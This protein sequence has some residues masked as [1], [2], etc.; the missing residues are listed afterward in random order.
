MRSAQDLS[1]RSTSVASP[2][3]HREKLLEKEEAS[4]KRIDELTAA[5][6]QLGHLP[7]EASG[8]GE[9]RSRGAL[10]RGLLHIGF[11]VLLITMVATDNPSRGYWTVRA[12]NLRTAV[13][14]CV[15]SQR[16]LPSL[17]SMPGSLREST[18]LSSAFA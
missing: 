5:F 7:M 2:S 16:V 8:I 4:Q 9:A 10:V 3:R 17:P 14:L 15:P 13:V 6:K 11:T 18:C 12:S 1:E